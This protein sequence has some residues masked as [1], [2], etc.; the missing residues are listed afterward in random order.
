M[1]RQIILLLFLG[2]SAVAQTPTE[3]ATTRFTNQLVAVYNTGDSINFKTYFAGLTADQAQITANSHRMH[4]E[5]AQIGPVQLRQ[6]VGISPTRTE[7]LL[8]TNAYDS[9]WKLVV[10]TDSTNHFK[11]HHMWPVRLSSEGLSSAKL[12]ETQILTGIDTYITKLQS[13]H[14]FAGNVLIA[15]NNQVIYAKSCGNNPQG[16]PNSKDQP[17]NLASLGKLFTSISIL[18]LVDSGK[19][20]LNDSVGKFMPEIKNKALHSITIRQLLTHTSGMGD[21]FENPAYQPEAG[22]VITREEF[23]PAIENDKPQFRPGAA[24]GYSNTGFLLLGLLI[25]KV[26]GS[27][28]ADF[29]NKNTLLPAGM[30]QTSLDSGAGGGFSTSSDIYK[31]AQ[32]IRR[33]KLLKKK[34]QEQF[35]TEHTPDWGLGQEYQALGGEVVTG[36]SGGYIGVCTELNMYRYSGYTVIILS[37]TEPPYGHFVSDKIKE[38]ILSK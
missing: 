7:L 31:F 18:Q 38:M 19:L 30:H 22:K 4:R 27:S 2:I 13:K 8:K 5:F 21:F 25:E 23:L 12:T 32:A 10:L 15:R 33:G 11:E 1:F 36:H 14:V 26:T 17:F 9:W 29:V 3:T 28:F 24:F 6:T 37:N 20:S 16:R 35:L 34:T